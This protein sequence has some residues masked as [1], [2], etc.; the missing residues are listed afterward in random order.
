MALMNW[1]RPVR[2]SPTRRRGSVRPKLEILEDRL[3]PAII[4]VTTN[5]DDPGTVSSVAPLGGNGTMAAP[6]LFETLRD[7]ILFSN[8]TDPG[9]PNFGDNVPGSTFAPAGGVT[10]VANEIDF[11]LDRSVPGGLQINLGAPLP[12]V[13][14]FAVDINGFS[15]A[16]IDTTNGDQNLFGIIT[17]VAGGVGDMLTIQQSD[18]I[19]EGLTFTG[20]EQAGIAVRNGTVP[21][22][23]VTIR[24]DRLINNNYGVRLDASDNYVHACC[25]GITD[26]L[27][28]VPG[29]NS[30]AGVLIDNGATGCLVDH[31]LIAANGYG[32]EIT[33]AGTSGNRLE[34]NGIGFDP[35]T[36]DGKFFRYD[37]T[38]CPMENTV[39]GVY[40]TGGASGNI[41]GNANANL[42]NII[43]GQGINGEP[44]V[45]ISDAGDGNVVQ[46]NFIGT[47]GTGEGDRAGFGPLG[48][49]L[50]V[51]I[52]GSST[53]NTQVRDNTISAN[54]TDGIDVRNFASGTLIKSN[55][56]GITFNGDK[57]LGNGRYG[58]NLELEAQN[59]TIDNNVI[60]AN[61]QP[62]VPSG[63]GGS[64]AGVYIQDD[65]TSGNLVQNNYVGTNF[66]G[67]DFSK[68]VNFGNLGVG[69]FLVGGVSGNTITHNNI[70]DNA[71]HGIAM[72]GT[73]HGNT[74]TSNQVWGNQEDGVL[75]L[76]ASNADL[77]S[78]NV[79]ANALSGFELD[80]ALNNTLK[81]NLVQ[82]NAAV[83]ILF[84]GSAHNTVASSNIT[85]NGADGVLLEKNSSANL[86]G[87]TANG[88][89]NTI[90]ANG[91]DGV[92][93]DGTSNGDSILH[94]SIFNNVQAGIALSSGG[95]S[96][97]ATP[98]IS[99]VI[100]GNNQITINVA[101]GPSGPLNIEI[102]KGDS[103]TPIEGQTL[104]GV[105]P[106]TVGAGG[107]FAVNL[108]GTYTGATITLTLT[109]A[110]GNTSG[111]AAV[112]A[113]TKLVFTSAP[114]TL[115]AGQASGL[116]TVQLRD[117]NGNLA[118]APATGLVVHLTSDSSGGTFLDANGQPLAGGNLVFAP[119]T[120][121]A[122]FE[123][124]DATTGSPTLVA[125][126]AG[127]A[128]A[129]QQESVDPASITFPVAVTSITA[130]AGTSF[131]GM[132]ASFSISNT[133]VSA[134]AFSAVIAWGD[135]QTSTVGV[136]GGSG[137]F[138]ISG[139]HTYA[140]QGRFLLAV[141]VN[142]TGG[143][144]G[145][146]FGLAH[147]ATPN[148]P[149]PAALDFVSLALTTSPEYYTN[150]VTSI[151]QK[152]LHRAPDG[153]GLAGWVQGLQGGLTDEQLE[154]FFIG[155]AEYIASKGAGAGNWMPWVV[156]MYQDLL[157]RTPSQAEAQQWVNGLNAGI[158]T[159]F[160]AHG[161]A[162]SAE[163]ESGRVT[164]DYLRYLGRSPTA[165]EVQQWVNAFVQGLVT[166]EYVIA[167]FLGSAEYFAN[168]YADA[169]DY[170]FSTYQAALGR[171]PDAGS[172]QNWLAFLEA[173]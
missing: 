89:G 68:A 51:E 164:A 90:N 23:N 30:L 47:N 69:V 31:S 101:S 74:V 11:Q 115:T 123:Y 70:D 82:G 40:V 152:Y 64:G 148:A 102:F 97:I 124:K 6:F 171:N 103:S 7:A 150:L 56:I 107:A 57:A 54:V 73:T 50:G 9:D 48:N 154:A 15:Q 105:G 19:V 81:S 172:L 159:A 147:V 27:N 108:P 53:T 22:T 166:N 161:F 92:Q 8:T 127:L 119:E 96:G 137:H 104:I 173:S 71:G 10:P 117:W 155:S 106:I 126:A 78:N 168:H 46:Q 146:G 41:I 85:A 138:T 20:T 80:G 33:G 60:S 98:V 116:V 94:N 2:T 28:H 63:P 14:K 109:D 125:T 157:G 118:L 149:P 145:A 79:Q 36:F 160:V 35:T 135:G 131:S 4:A 86:I 44:G 24:S 128:A 1:L 16:G 143:N 156:S 38:D 75:L 140:R 162:A 130:T 153:P 76:N 42:G 88:T 32:V 120:S 49:Y 66:F 165:A 169:V 163:R 95:N 37:L 29:G 141:T 39:T 133:S 121:A 72:N 132:V 5:A 91:V 167:G 21:T 139:S 134:S 3:A 87:G 43:S 84:E 111:F 13:V 55:V 61:G 144:T 129:S 52:S 100:A 112:I 58:I 67:T 142:Q 136:S 18:C 62:A 26:P 110:A 65:G 45:L 151:Y 59:T 122:S 114:Q 93:V 17:V 83:G 34:I 25:I 158:S 170:L 99:S 77:E 12:S 113:P